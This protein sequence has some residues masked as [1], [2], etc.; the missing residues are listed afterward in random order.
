MI[1]LISTLVFAAAVALKGGHLEKLGINLPVLNGFHLSLLL[2]GAYSFF[3]LP[4]FGAILFIAGFALLRMSMGEEAGAVGDYAG[5]WG[6]Y[7]DKGFGRSYGVKKA[8]QYGAFAG[9]FMALALGG[10]W[11]MWLAGVAM[12]AVYFVGNSLYRFKHGT[13]SWAY[14]EPLWGAALGIAFALSI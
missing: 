3:M 13:S 4:L 11:P 9:G 1:L 10:A 2:V 5:A 14:S 8:A 6:E 12:P 7:I